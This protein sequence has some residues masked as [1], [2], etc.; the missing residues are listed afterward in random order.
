MKNRRSVGIGI[1]TGGR[2][3]EEREILFYRALV[4]KYEREY[5]VRIVRPYPTSLD[6]LQVKLPADG[7]IFL[8]LLEGL[9]TFDE[10]FK[11]VSFIR[12]ALLWVEQ[13]GYSSS[14]VAAILQLTEVY[15]KVF[16]VC[17][18]SLVDAAVELYHEDE[19]SLCYEPWFESAEA[20][21]LLPLVVDN[22]QGW[23]GEAPESLSFLSLKSGPGSVSSRQNHVLRWV[24]PIPFGIWDVFGDLE[25]FFLRDDIPLLGDDPSCRM[26]AVPKTATKPRLISAEPSWLS[27]G[28]QA[29]RQEL[30]DKMNRFPFMSIKTQDRNARLALRTDI[31]TIDQSRASDRIPASLVTEV[32]PLSWG[33]LLSNTRSASVDCLCG[34]NH[35]LCKFAGMGSATTFP[36]ETIVFAA[37]VVAALQRELGTKGL[38]EDVM[39]KLG[40]FGDDVIV[41]TEYAQL[42]EHALSTFGFLVNR[43]KSYSHGGFRESC[44]VYSFRGVDVTPLRRSQ[45]LPDNGSDVDRTEAI[46]SFLNGMM[47][48]FKDTE[49]LHP[50]TGIE[51]MPAVSLDIDITSA[52]LGLV[53][54]KPGFGIWNGESTSWDS[55]PERA[56]RRSSTFRP[57]DDREESTRMKLSLLKLEQESLVNSRTPNHVVPPLLRSVQVAVTADRQYDPRPIGSRMKIR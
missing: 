47:L 38:S 17:E 7:N 42:V 24:D 13:S 52:K 29:V 1:S 51:N 21:E 10:A 26:I 19:K 30:E 4:L 23:L 11:A 12:P 32:F 53:R 2:P 14:S 45:W 16:E 3:R 15:K 56:V 20:L 48:R 25:D 22:I 35:P 37:V 34:E 36:V 6:D 28:Q 27:F 55:F 54:T 57:V 5:G 50:L 40:I 8:R 9:I 44:G 46:T 31:A 43:E 39:S 49:D 33:Y 18:S 41:P